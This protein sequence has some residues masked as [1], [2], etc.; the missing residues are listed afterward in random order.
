MRP[1]HFSEFAFMRNAQ[2]RIFEIQGYLRTETVEGL[3]NKKEHKNLISILFGKSEMD[4][5]IYLFLVS[6]KGCSNKKRCAQ[7]SC[8]IDFQ[9][10]KEK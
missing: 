1:K 9:N 4:S 7:I 10:P 3:Y 2:S 5:F 8:T 6:K